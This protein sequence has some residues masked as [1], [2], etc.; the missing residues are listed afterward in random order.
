[1]HDSCPVCSYSFEREPGYFV[2]AMYISYGLA[3]PLYLAVAGILRLLFR[4]WSDLAVLALALPLFVPFAPFLF[5]YSRVLW[6]HFDLAIDR[7]R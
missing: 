6:M 4:G 5:R 7:G 2:G 3:I 1:M